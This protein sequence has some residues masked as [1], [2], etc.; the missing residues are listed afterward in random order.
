MHGGEQAIDHEGLVYHENATS[1]ENTAPITVTCFN[2]A[3]QKK[4]V[5][6]KMIRLYCLWQV[7]ELL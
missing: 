7:T 3:W 4:F 5:I 2:S 1:S 6:G